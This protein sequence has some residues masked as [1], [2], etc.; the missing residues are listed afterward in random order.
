MNSPHLLEDITDILNT[1]L[2]TSCVTDYVPVSLIIVADSGCAKSKIIKAFS[3]DGIHFTDS[4]TSQGLFSLMQNDPTN[5]LRYILVPDFNPTLSRQPKTLNATIA[6]LLT[7]TMDGTCR[8]DDG[9][10]EKKLVHKPIGLISAVTPDIY[11]KQTRKWLSLGLTRRIIP[12]FY[13]YKQET[14]RKLLDVVAEGKITSGDFPTSKIDLNESHLPTIGDLHAKIIESMSMALAA[15][16]GMQEY[17]DKKG[18]S[19][20][21]MKKIVPISPT[22]LLR[23]LAQA[24]AIRRRSG[25]IEDV[26]MKFLS[27]FLEFTN[28]ASI[29]Q[30]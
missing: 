20:W 5:K 18:K 24:N 29:R 28:P 12:I 15:H 21:D 3:G 26:D 23:T 30:I 4:F 16:L 17:K 11:K 22:V 6:N 14:V 27:K 10:Q 8:V 13:E 1:V 7:L 19:K 9:R 25:K 2:Y